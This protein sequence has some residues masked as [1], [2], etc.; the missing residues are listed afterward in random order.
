MVYALCL[1]GA[2]VNH[3]QAVFARGWLPEQLPLGTALYWSSLTIVDPIAVVLLF[4]RPRAGIADGRDHR[5]QRGS[6][7]LLHGCP[8]T[9]RIDLPGRDIQHLHDESNRFPAVRGCHGAGCL[10]RLQAISSARLIF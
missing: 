10:A 1:A 4:L 7:S 8:P 6:Q 2:T 3:V 9:W 5:F